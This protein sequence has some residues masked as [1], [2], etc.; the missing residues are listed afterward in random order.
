MIRCKHG[1][2]ADRP[3]VSET[4]NSFLRDSEL[5]MEKGAN[6]HAP[7]FVQKKEKTMAQAKK[8][9]TKKRDTRALVWLLGVE[10][11]L[12]LVEVQNDTAVIMLKTPLN[13]KAKDLIAKA[14]DED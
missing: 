14:K 8:T 10:D 5:Q 6:W 2:Q 3:R 7:F 9:E 11:P 13:K 1:D 12:E 4:N